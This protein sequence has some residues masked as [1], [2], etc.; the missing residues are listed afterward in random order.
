MAKKGDWIRIHNIVLKAEERTAKI[1]EDTKRCDLEMWVKGFLIEDSAEC[2]DVVSV[3]TAAGRVQS[4]VLLEERPHYT[5]SYGE[6]VPEIIEID[7]R[8]RKMMFGGEK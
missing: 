5:H 2:G 3:E 7:K 8:I 4:G 1:P 6:F